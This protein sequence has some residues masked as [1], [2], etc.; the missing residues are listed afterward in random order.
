[1]RTPAGEAHLDAEVAPIHVVSQEQVA[2]VAGGAP[3]LKKLHQIEELPVNVP[4][5]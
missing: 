1:M 2:G 3:H 4:T 5:H